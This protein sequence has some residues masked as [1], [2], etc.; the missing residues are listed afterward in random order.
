MYFTFICDCIGSKSDWKC[1][2]GTHLCWSNFY[3]VDCWRV[4]D[5]AERFQMTGTLAVVQ[6][7]SSARIVAS[8]ITCNHRMYWSCGLATTSF[9]GS[10]SCSVQRSYVRGWW[11]CQ[12]STT[13]VWVWSLAALVAACAGGCS[14]SDS[15]VITSNYSPSTL[16]GHGNFT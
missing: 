5:N 10:F 13:L 8:C 11:W 4:I 7:R 16:D 14:V 12:S 1:Q 9:Y 3:L 6:S 2:I 15:V